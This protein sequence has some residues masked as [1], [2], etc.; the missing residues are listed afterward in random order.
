MKIKHLLEKMCIVT[1]TITAITSIPLL[2]NYLRQVSPKFKLIVDL[3][4]WFGL[5]F[6]ILV[7]VRIVKNKNFIHA[8]IKK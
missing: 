6:I 4:V 5:T 8:I 1:F 2:L 3:H 7:L